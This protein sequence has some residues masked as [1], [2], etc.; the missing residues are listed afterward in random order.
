VRRATT[1]RVLGSHPVVVLSHEGWRQA[2]GERPDI[3]G[4]TVL[5]NGL[6][7]PV[8]GVAAEGF[9]GT[10]TGVAPTLWPPITMTRQLSA[11]GRA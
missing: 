7:F 10:R 5:I 4:R 1:Y 3:V 6:P 2:F 11:G 9:F 8:V